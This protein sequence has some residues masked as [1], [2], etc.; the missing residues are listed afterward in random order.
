ML[1]PILNHHFQIHCLE[2]HIHPLVTLEGAGKAR[3]WQPGSDKSPDD[4]GCPQ[5]QGR[6]EA[7]LWLQNLQD[8]T[9]ISP[10]EDTRDR[11]SPRMA[12][13]SCVPTRQAQSRPCQ[14]QPKPAGPPGRAGVELGTL[15]GT[16]GLGLSWNGAPGPMGG[17]CGW[18]NP[19][20]ADQGN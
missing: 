18:G 8:M 9:R 1:L 16:Q 20:E 3:G 12:R 11:H 15:G 4:R 2:Y 7:K 5:W 13:L 10:A 6:P 14:A 19:G 17:A